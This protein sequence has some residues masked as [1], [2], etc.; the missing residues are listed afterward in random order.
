MYIYYAISI[1]YIVALMLEGKM[2]FNRY[3]KNDALVLSKTTINISE[4]FVQSNTHYKA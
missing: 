4:R 3:V 1:H 2:D